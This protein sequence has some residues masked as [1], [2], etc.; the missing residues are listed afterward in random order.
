MGRTTKTGHWLLAILKAPC[1][2]ENKNSSILW[3]VASWVVVDLEK[4]IT[5]LTKK[6]YHFTAGF[7]V[8]EETMCML[9]PVFP[10]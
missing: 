9:K 3:T 7:K 6:R 1:L 2:E 5:P 4:T 10:V 8:G